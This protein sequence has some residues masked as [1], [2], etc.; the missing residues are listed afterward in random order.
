MRRLILVAILCLTQVP[1]LA[2]TGDGSPRRQPRDAATPTLQEAGASRRGPPSSRRWLEG[3]DA[4]MD[5][6]AQAALQLLGAEF[7]LFP[8]AAVDLTRTSLV[9]LRVGKMDPQG[10]AAKA[11]IYT[12]DVLFGVYEPDPNMPR[13]GFVDGHTRS[14]AAFGRFLA[15]FGTGAK[16]AL[17]VKLEKDTVTNGPDYTRVTHAIVTLGPATSTAAFVE[18][19]RPDNSYGLERDR[20]IAQFVQWYEGFKQTD[21]GRRGAEANLKY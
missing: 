21:Q 11:G 17:Q 16:V 9:G 6:Q 15:R 8:G 4:P 1:I 13:R 5:E 14:E 10:A 19:P 2:Q 20:A 18:R 12:G 3:T 7:T